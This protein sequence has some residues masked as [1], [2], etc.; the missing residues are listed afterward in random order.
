MLLPYLDLIGAT[1]A[2]SI[3]GHGGAVARLPVREVLKVARRAVKRGGYARLSDGPAICQALDERLGRRHELGLRLS[4]FEVKFFVRV[5]EGDHIN[6]EEGRA[7]V[8]SS[9][10]SCGP[11]AVS[12]TGSSCSSTAKS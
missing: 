8:L 9:S 4:D 2:S 11:A 5:H 3:Y 7:L 12:A 6:I 1:D 10:G